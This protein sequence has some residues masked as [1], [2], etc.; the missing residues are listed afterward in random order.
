LP[1][2]GVC[3]ELDFVQQRQQAHLLIDV[4]PEEKLSA[5]HSLLEV[6]VEPLSRILA[7]APVEEEELTPETVAA[8]KRSSAQFDRGESVSHEEILREF[9][10]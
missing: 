5:I 6:L 8:L 7:M 9:V 2:L 4:L 10:R 1:A 3:M